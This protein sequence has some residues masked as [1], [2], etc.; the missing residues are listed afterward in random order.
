MREDSSAAHHPWLP[1]HNPF[2]IPIEGKRLLRLVNHPIVTRQITMCE[3]PIPTV[4]IGA[5]SRSELRCNFP[6][7]ETHRNKIFS[8]GSYRSSPSSP[9]RI[10][11]IGYDRGSSQVDDTND[12]T[13]KNQLFFLRPAKVLG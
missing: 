5:F 10:A 3:F 4:T 2:N 8:M 11:G 13:E 12:D 6:M 9:T 1:D 7:H